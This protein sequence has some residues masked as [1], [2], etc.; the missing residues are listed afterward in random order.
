MEL[1]PILST[2]IL[3]AT[4][5]TFILSIGAYVLYK[6][7]ERRTTAVPV[8]PPRTMQ[9]ELVIPADVVPHRL[10]AEQTKQPQ[11]QSPFTVQKPSEGLTG[12]RQRSIAPEAKQFS[13]DETVK[14]KVPR[15]NNLRKTT[16]NKFLKYTT[17]GY[18]PTEEDK[19]IGAFKWR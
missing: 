9:A 11:Y 17:E 4:I 10:T 14:Y 5:S 13:V 8:V 6:I 15:Q 16:E 12:G 1:I 7:R 2:I 18:V 19:E 3:V